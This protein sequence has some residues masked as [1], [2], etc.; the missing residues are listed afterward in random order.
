MISLVNKLPKI[1]EYNAEFLK[2]QCLYD[3]YCDDDRVM[4]W[5]QDEAKAVIAMTDGN[6]I[7]Y[8][9]NADIEELKEFIDVLCPACIFSDLETLKNLDRIPQE[10]I[11]IMW[12]MADVQSELQS[13]ILSSKE[14]YSLLDVDGLSLPEYPFFAVDYCRRL[15]K[16]SA[17]YF[18]IK[19]KCAVIT[20]HS[21]KN[22]IING[23][24]SHEKGY[25]SIALKGILTKNYG[26]KLLVCCRD[27]VKGFYENNGFELLYYAGYWVKT[28]E[29]N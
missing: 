8:N 17:N 23:I 27:K 22:A 25:G 26:K 5:C 9:N 13:D 12:R 28:N 15:N 21:G 24:A 18:G 3:C 14:L 7:I 20:F 29:Y 2:I 4:F 16:G 11:N 6:M 1:K 10:R 19:E